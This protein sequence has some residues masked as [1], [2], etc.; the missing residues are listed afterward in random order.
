MSPSLSVGRYLYA[1]ASLANNGT[2]FHFQLR[3]PMP[4]VSLTKVVRFL[5]DDA[6]IPLA[7]LSFDLGDGSSRAATDVRKSVV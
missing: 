1:A 5:V 2:G 3:C 7:D 4:G 6:E